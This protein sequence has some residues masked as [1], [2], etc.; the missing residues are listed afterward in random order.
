MESHDPTYCVP[1]STDTRRARR[2]CPRHART[3]PP[4]PP[5]LGWAA[6]G[7]LPRL[8]LLQPSTPLLRYAFRYFNERARLPFPRSGQQWLGLN[9]Y[10]YIHSTTT[11]IFKGSS[12]SR[13]RVRPL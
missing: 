12:S 10:V 13:L 6:A 8:L 3:S 7:P 2:R 1:P 5:S 4:P 11:F 9:S